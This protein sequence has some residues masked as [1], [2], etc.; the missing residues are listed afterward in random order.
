MK[1][2][3]SGL[4]AEMEDIWANLFP[5]YFF[6]SHLNQEKLE[7]DQSRK[8]ETWAHGLDQTLAS[9]T[10]WLNDFVEFPVS[11]L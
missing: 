1:G 6:L 8:Q 5:V 2:S 11:G 9:G 3:R 4:G 10:H 7:G